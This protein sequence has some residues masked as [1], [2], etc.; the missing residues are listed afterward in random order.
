MKDKNINQYSS[1][2]MKNKNL[3]IMEICQT[4]ISTKATTT[5]ATTAKSKSIKTKNK[6]KISLGILYVRSLSFKWKI[7]R[8]DFFLLLCREVSFSMRTIER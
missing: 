6:N 5:T 7:F 3:S 2:A 4:V 8:V 1:K